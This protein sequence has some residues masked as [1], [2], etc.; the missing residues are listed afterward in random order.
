MPGIPVSERR[1]GFW[2]SGMDTVPQQFLDRG[3][4]TAVVQESPGQDSTVLKEKGEWEAKKDH[5]VKA[6]SGKTKLE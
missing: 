2:F 1:Q 5:A 3:Y 6:W 4:V